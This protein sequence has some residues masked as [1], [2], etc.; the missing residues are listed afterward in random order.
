MKKIFSNKPTSFEPYSGF[1]ISVYYKEELVALF[2][3]CDLFE[4]KE[5]NYFSLERGRVLN[6]EH[7]FDV[8]EKNVY[9]IKINFPNFNYQL[10]NITVKNVSDKVFGRRII[11]NKLSGTYIKPI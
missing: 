1:D 3:F 7:I 6:P 2:Q 10:E 11:V 8:N 4:E 9:K 5:T